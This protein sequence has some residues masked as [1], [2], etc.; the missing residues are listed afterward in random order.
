MF[1]ANRTRPLGVTIIAILVA[2][3]GIFDVIVG[4][5]GLVILIGIIPLI[6]GILALILAAGLWNLRTW[7]FWATVILAVLNI[8]NDIFDVTRNQGSHF[9]SI[10]LWVIVL[11]YM[12]LD[13]NVR[14]AFRT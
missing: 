14:A 5:L 4:I 7:A 9:V 2:I 13:R 3:V 11:V 6:L 1:M 8:I 10:A 12:L